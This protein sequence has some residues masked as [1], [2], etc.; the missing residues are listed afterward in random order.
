MFDDLFKSSSTN[1]IGRRGDIFE[2][3][4]YPKKSREDFNDVVEMIVP[5]TKP[6][7]SNSEKPLVV[8]IDDDFPTI[9][10]MKIYLQRGYE[11]MAFDNPREAIFFLNKRVPDL[12]FL[13]CYM[14]TI[15]T[16]RI[17]DIIRSYPEFA[18]VPI[19]LL[20]EPDEIGAMT[21]KVQKEGYL[22]ISGIITRPVARGELQAI[23]D[24]EFADRMKGASS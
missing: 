15:K 19:Y 18:T 13:D 23:L 14:S 12:I 9:D 24:V 20:A 2:S 17:L 7:K 11:Y 21:A 6:V 8:L 3:E 4:Y 1:S 5:P 22:G 16:K 10:L